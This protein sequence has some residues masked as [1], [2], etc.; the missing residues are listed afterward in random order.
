VQLTQAGGRQRDLFLALATEDG[1]DVR[2][3]ESSS[4]IRHCYTLVSRAGTTTEIVEEADPVAPDTEQR[5]REAYAELIDGVASVVFSGTKAAGFSDSLYPDLVAQAIALGK[6]VVLDVR[7]SD[8]VRSLEYAPTVAKPNYDEFLAT[9]FAGAARDDEALLPD[10]KVLL[11][12]LSRRHGS[13]FVLTRGPLPA[14]VCDGQSVIEVPPEKVPALNPTGS[15]DAFTAAMVRELVR[16]RSL[17]DAV[18]EGHT[19]GAANAVR[20]RPGVVS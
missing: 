2:W 13:A 18:A 4:E 10:V 11:H 8:L 5:V 7:G 20:L 14:L 15:G 12:E 1:I 19:A 16:G 6:T 3:V 17:T 9:F